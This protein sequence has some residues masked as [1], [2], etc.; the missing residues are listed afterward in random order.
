MSQSG[1]IDGSL[2]FPHTYPQIFGTCCVGRV[3]EVG[4]DVTALSPGQLV[5]CDHIVYLRDAPEHRI[6][7]GECP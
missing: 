6:V 2:K 7:L 4:P 1:V 5:F 3:D